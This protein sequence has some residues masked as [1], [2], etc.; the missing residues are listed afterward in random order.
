MFALNKQG[1]QLNPIVHVHRLHMTLCQGQRS[2]YRKN[3]SIRNSSSCRNAKKLVR[4]MGKV[5]GRS[6]SDVVVEK[7]ER[8][9]ASLGFLRDTRALLFTSSPFSTR[10]SPNSSPADHRP[11]CVHNHPHYYHLSPRLTP[12]LTRRVAYASSPCRA[13]QSTSPSPTGRSSN[14]RRIT[15]PP[16]FLLRRTRPLG[17]RPS[18]ST[19]MSTIAPW[20]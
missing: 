10:S 19:S 18:P 13:P 16:L 5:A 2:V 6:H 9:R 1:S 3:Y 12:S 7:L 11:C 14:S 17:S 8:G 4:R 15:S 20:T